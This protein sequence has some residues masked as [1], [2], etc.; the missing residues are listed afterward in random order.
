MPSSCATTRNCFEVSILS[1]WRAP[2]RIREFPMPPFWIKSQ[3]RGLRPSAPGV[4]RND[5]LI[6]SGE[7]A[8]GRLT[9]CNRSQG[10]RHER[11]VLAGS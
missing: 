2:S 3:D 4:A 8:I 10:I 11:P 9:L 5:Y 7:F 1:A 6:L